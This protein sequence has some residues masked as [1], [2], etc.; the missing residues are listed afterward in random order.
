M[1]D[2]YA[3]DISDFL[4]YALLRSLARDDYKLGVAWYYNRDGDR[5]PDG[6]H[7]DYIL[8]DKWDALDKTLRREVKRF[9][10]ESNADP[11]YRTVSNIERLEIWPRRTIF[12]G[13]Q[14]GES[15]PR[16]SRDRFQW[17]K[18]MVRKLDG[19]QIIFSDPDNGARD[20]PTIRHATYNEIRILSRA[21]K[22]LVLIK[23]PAFV[24]YEIQ[25]KAHS[26]SLRDHAGASN[27]ITLR[28]Q[29]LVRTANNRQNLQ[30]RRW[31]TPINFDSE[32][33]RRF[34]AFHVKLSSIDG[35]SARID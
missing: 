10:F 16:F 1:R 27:S 19:C 26:E 4:K 7:T 25:L 33:E 32:L 22:P 24:P 31:F 14:P 15:I 11:K 12:H 29:T 28:T 17:S 21:G 2:Q 34:R 20:R 18:G 8:E 23:F 35:V 6:R 30:L 5:R 3:G 13:T 9:Y